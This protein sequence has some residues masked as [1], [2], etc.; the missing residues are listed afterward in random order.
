MNPPMRRSALLELALL[1]CPKSFRDDYRE[2]IYA[3]AEESGGDGAAALDVARYGI[4]VRVEGLARDVVL[5]LRALLKARMFSTVALG[6]LAL[7][8]S[9]NAAVFA[10]VQAV[11]LQPLPFA[12]SDR[13]AFLC[14]G[15]PPSCGF[16][17]DD[18]VV[19]AFARGGSGLGGVAAFQFGRGTLTGYG[20]PQN[21]FAAIAST[22]ALDVLGARVELGRGF[23]RA[24]GAAGARDVLISDDLWRRVF[25]ADPRAVGTSVVIDT[26]RYRI[27][28]VVAPG[29]VVPS[30]QMDDPAPLKID[31]WIAHADAPFASFGAMHDWT[32]VRLAPGV[33]PAAAA[34]QVQRITAAIRREHPLD[35]RELAV[36]AVPFGAW[37]HRRSGTFLMLLSAAALAVLVIACANVANLLLV[38]TVTRRGELALRSALGA[39]RGRIVRELL[40]EIALVA[41]AGGALGLLLA[42][43]ELRLLTN[44]LATQLPAVA[45]SRVGAGVVL[46]TFG[47]VVAATLLSGLL[48]A[49]SAT[50]SELAGALKS[51]GRGADGGRVKALRTA[52]AAVEI[53]LAFGVVALSALLVRSS[54]ALAAA[55]LGLDPHGVYLAQTSLNAS[56]YREPAARAAFARELTAR[57][58]AL[59]GVEAAAVA[60]H[61]QY[62]YNGTELS[63]YRLPGRAYAANTSADAAI[64]Q[65]SSDYF[66]ALRIPLVTGRAFAPSDDANA[67]RVAIVDETVARTSFGGRSPVGARILIP[68]AGG[69]LPATIVGEARNATPYGRRDDTRVYVPNAQV[70]ST[71]PELVVRMRVPDPQLREHVA[72]ALAHVDP[73]QAL[74]DFV[75][76]DE[77]VAAANAPLATSAALLTILAAVALLLAL[78]GI[79][80]I[81][82]YSV[83]QRRHEFGIRIAVGA[84]SGDIARTVLAGALRVAALGIACGLIAAAVGTRS[85]DALL[86]GV[87]RFDPLTFAA[88]AGLVLLCVALASAIPAARAMRVDPAVALRYE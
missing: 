67:P 14:P 66:R 40:V 30:P 4:G 87:T 44:A 6:T 74:A 35:A 19:G 68:S 43:A 20:L 58:A 13:L 85:L 29:T 28:G 27:A 86:Y 11:L 10:V 33:S 60:R 71:Y 59:P 54:V 73:N 76:L 45:G 79:Y 56:R 1:L 31:L 61:A 2:Q 62:S 16:Q 81:V 46:F 50:G 39:S 41:L 17:L 26:E 49:L 15:S 38:R 48:P 36:A 21:L 24:D 37:Y 12:H 83:E 3:H 18:G 23:T 72:A 47:V 32:F 82:A 75:S 51:I 34:A 78:G 53:A 69:Y 88:V 5:A 64:T 52:L 77:R 84:R 8:I 42:G 7:A 25:A 22:N 80:A 57:V 70:P 63:G 9:V 55:P 65:V